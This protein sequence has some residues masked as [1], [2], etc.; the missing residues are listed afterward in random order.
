M[1]E[2]RDVS[3]AFHVE[4]RTF[5][6]ICGVSLRVEDG[7][8][9]GIVGESGAGKS[10]LLRTINL[11]Q[12]PTSGRVLVDG[13]DLTL[14]SP[15]ELRAQ[16]ARIGM[17][18]QH[19]SLFMRKTVYENVAFPLRI[20]GAARAQ[21]AERVPEL[22]R[23]VGLE[24]KAGAF[25]ARLSGGQRQRVG[26]ARALANRP[27]VLLCDEP[28][29]ALDQETSGAILDLLKRI[30]GELGITVVLIS[31]DMAVI[32]KAS[33]RVA[34]M[35]AGEVVECRDV[36][37]L[38]A[39]P[40][41]PYARQLVAGTVDLSVPPRVRESVHGP[42]LLLTYR[43]EGAER[44]VLAEAAREL[45]AEF[46]VL[47]GRIEYINERP[48]GRLVVGVGSASGGSGAPGLPEVRR[49]LEERGVSCETL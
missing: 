34:V 25:P 35:K 20:A 15:P 43:G 28:T 40:R 29:S 16:R 18:F 41:H 10:T 17:I 4:G 30:N 32:K 47:H 42:L 1:I 33:R 37:D 5:D 46:N 31:H 26:I 48:L 24:E 6:A 12:R 44:P 27:S 49:F 39:E 9:F 36:Y 2:L 19:F 11:L 22:L 45:G 21:I 3:V 23:V 7:E 8:F 38:F 13:R 14:M